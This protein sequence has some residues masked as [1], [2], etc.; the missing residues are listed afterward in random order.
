[1]EPAG[2]SGFGNAA[3]ADAGGADSNADVAALHDGANALQIHVPAP[4]GDIVSVTDPVA[5]ARSFA[6]N[7]TYSC[8]LS[9]FSDLSK[10][11]SKQRHEVE[12]PPKGTGISLN[13]FRYSETRDG[14]GR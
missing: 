9:R 12:G 6:A 8:H 11:Y 3:G 7:F 2:K 4:F 13:P 1:M 5:K 10:K 14:R